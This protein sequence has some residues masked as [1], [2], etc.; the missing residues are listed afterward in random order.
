MLQDKT[1]RYHQFGCVDLAV[2]IN[3]LNNVTS[4]I[5]RSKLSIITKPQASR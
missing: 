5:P 3:E 1:S 2:S 4:P